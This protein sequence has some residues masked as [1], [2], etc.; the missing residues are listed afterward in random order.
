MYVELECG[1]LKCV[2]VHVRH[3]FCPF[4]FNTKLYPIL[5]QL[6][7]LTKDQLSIQS[8]QYHCNNCLELSVSSYKMFR[9]HHHFQ[10]KP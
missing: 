6:Y 3:L 2:P 1:L 8:I 10:G 9:Y 7:H 4:D 5:S